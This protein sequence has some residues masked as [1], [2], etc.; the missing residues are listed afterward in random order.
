MQ[1][2]FADVVQNL[3]VP[4]STAT[5]VERFGA[6][7]SLPSWEPVPRA[8]PKSFVYVAP[9]RTGKISCGTFASGRAP[10]GAAPT[11]AARTMRIRNPRAVVRLQGGIELRFA[12][13]GPYPSTLSGGSTA[14]GRGTVRLSR[15]PDAPALE[16]RAM[17]I[18]VCVKQV[19]ETAAKRI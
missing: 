7:R 6:I 4:G 8:S 12:L 18:A 5:A 16:S 2:A 14:P 15:R 1:P 11:T 19:P 13:E 17:K 10:A 9:P 3:T